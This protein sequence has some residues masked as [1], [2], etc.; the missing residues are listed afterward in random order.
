MQYS[1]P[2]QLLCNWKLPRHVLSP[3]SGWEGDGPQTPP[4]LHPPQ[5]IDILYPRL[6]L[7][8]GVHR[9]EGGQD[10]RLDSHPMPQLLN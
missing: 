9:G 1:E 7:S 2:C 3:L 4:P 5:Q 10:L 6:Q 8:L